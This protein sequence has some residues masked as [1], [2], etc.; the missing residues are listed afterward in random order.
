MTDTTFD[1]N[2][3]VFRVSYFRV[4]Y[5]QKV[6]EDF[7]RVLERHYRGDFGVVS[8]VSEDLRCGNEDPGMF[9]FAFGGIYERFREFPAYFGGI[10]VSS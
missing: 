5:F 8:G 6:L 2:C 3:W 7:Q 10:G 4:S 9:R 1:L